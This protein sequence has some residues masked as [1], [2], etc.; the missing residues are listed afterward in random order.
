MKIAKEDLIQDIQRVADKLSRTPTKREYNVYGEYSEGTIR[1][2]FGSWSDGVREAELEPNRQKHLPK[3]TK[4]E[5]LEDIEKVA[6]ALSKTPSQLEYEEHGEHSYTTAQARFG[7]WNEAVSQAGLEPNNRRR[8]KIPKEEL[9]NDLERVS[10]S[11]DKTPTMEEYN[12]HGEFNKTT[13]AERF[14]GWN[15]AVEA[16]GLEPNN[17]FGPYTAEEAVEDIQK[18]ADELGEA[19]IW[20]E[21]AECGKWS[22]QTIKEKFG[23]WPDAVEAA[24]L[25][26]RARGGG[27]Y[28]GGGFTGE[29]VPD[30]DLLDDLEEV[31]EEL[32]YPPVKAEYSEHGEYSGDTLSRRFG[33]WDQAM[34]EL[35]IEYTN[36]E[37][38]PAKIITD[39]RSVAEDLG[40]APT[41]Q[42]Y[43]EHGKHASQ[44]AQNRFGEW[45][46]AVRQAGLKPVKG[47]DDEVILMDLVEVADK[48]GAVPTPDEYDEHGVYTS[49]IVKER[50][51]GNWKVL[52][53]E[54]FEMAEEMNLAEV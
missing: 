36:G 35:G 49:N 48:L 23:T 44:T 6:A 46:E 19:P 42:E 17:K 18:V 29:S 33:G 11:L 43:D 2:R 3:F 13:L 14:E 4:E 25:E 47:A 52:A 39:I 30:S 7:T 53:L 45:N 1:N 40:R 41:G 38:H 9:L 15:N 31:V 28:F 20:D 8:A 50:F 10:E 16:A 26:P 21:Y 37:L 32:G 27:G 51:P 54:A 22:P 34:A 12:N 24:G 5:L